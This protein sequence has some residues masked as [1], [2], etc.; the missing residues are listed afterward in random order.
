ME[1]SSINE[2]SIG[3]I[4][5]GKVG[6]SLGKLFADR[7]LQVTGFYS[8]HQDSAREAS[9]FT[10]TDLFLD[11]ETIVNKSNTLFLTVPDGEI[12]KVFQSIRDLG[13]DGKYICHTSGSMS[14]AEAFE[15]IESVGAYGYS[16]HPL[17][18]VSSKYDSYLGLGDAFFC[19]ESCSDSYNPNPEIFRNG[20]ESL[21][22]KTFSIKPSDK[23]T[24]HAACVFASNLVC[25]VMAEVVDLFQSIGFD[26]KNAL[27]A[28]KPLV[29]SNIK[30]I[31]ERGPVEALTGPLER[32]DVITIN[33]HVEALSGEDLTLYKELSK[34]TLELAR[35]RHPE[36]DHSE[37][38][39][40][41]I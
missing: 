38:E 12:K 27:A 29:E 34:K 17:F 21:G 4:G 35:A 39:K 10:G 6:F 15:G 3:F 41:L 7:G 37:I 11:L 9:S 30:S 1:L 13:L 40:L 23:T 24:Y 18:P 2:L 16:I 26:E 14:S 31:L 19:I 36:Y 8:R 28:V 20:F 22:L 33:K 32:N 5:A 25:G